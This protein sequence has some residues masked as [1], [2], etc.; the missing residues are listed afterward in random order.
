[1]RET[2]FWEL[3]CSASH[4]NRVPR[5][6]AKACIRLVGLCTL[7]LRCE[8]PKPFSRQTRDTVNKGKDKMTTYPPPPNPKSPENK[9][10]TIGFIFAEPAFQ[11]YLLD[12]LIDQDETWAQRV[13][14]GDLF[15]SILL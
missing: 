14:V 6:G 1:M 5:K 13:S 12:G 4:V 15:H 3:P 2:H 9:E 7:A 10:P 8:K 11:R